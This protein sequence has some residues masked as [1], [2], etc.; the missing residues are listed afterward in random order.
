MVTN[1][2]IPT[3]ERITPYLL[4]RRILPTARAT[5]SRSEKQSI[6]ASHA[7]SREVE[8]S[9]VK[10]TIVGERGIHRVLRQDLKGRE[11]RESE[12][13][14]NDELQRLGPPSQLEACRRHSEARDNHDNES[15]IPANPEDHRRDKRHERQQGQR[16]RDSL[17]PL[18]PRAY[19][20]LA[21]PSQVR[22]ITLADCLTALWTQSFFSARWRTRSEPARS[23]NC[24]GAGRRRSPVKAPG[25]LVS[26]SWVR[27][28][29]GRK[30]SPGGHSSARQGGSSEPF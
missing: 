2:P 21:R 24:A 7:R 16:D 1:P 14:R 3:S 28:P 18:Q 10:R 4:P 22:H 27:H 25:G 12:H 20:H 8:L 6:C 9:R 5:P 17:A 29:G 30:T 15:R 11:N 26:C 23:A 19:R 13:L